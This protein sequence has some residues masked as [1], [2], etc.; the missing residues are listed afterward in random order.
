[1]FN[2]GNTLKHRPKLSQNLLALAFYV[3]LSIVV[4][5]PALVHLRDRVLG[6]YPGDNFQFLWAL[7][8]TAHA[9]ID[10][11][12]SPFFDPSIYFPFGFSLF[13]NLGEVSPA[14][15][16]VS[17]PLTRLLGEVATYNLLI[18]TSFALTGFATFL[19]AR[20]LRAGFPGAL[21]A[22][23]GVGFCSYHFAHAGGHLSLASTQWIPFFFLYL[24]RILQRPSIRKA[25]LLGLFYA[26]SALVSWY[27]ASLLPIAA[28]LYLSLR[29]NYFKHPKR[30]ARL[31]KPGLA[32]V[33]CSAVLVLP[34][35]VPYVLALKHG[36]MET[37]SLEES[38]AFSASVADFFIPSVRHPLF[39]R[40]IAQHWRSGAN[41]LWGEWEV[42]LGTLIV[43][44]ALLGIIRS[45]D[46]RITAGLIAMG[47]GAF[48][49]ALGPTL[50]FVHPPSLRGAANLAPLSHIP[51]PVLALKDIPPFSFLRC[52][53]RMGFFLELA[54]SLLAAKGLTY[55]LELVP[56]RAI[57]RHAVAIIVISLAT[58]DSMAV[59]FGMALVA[60][61]PV[62][63]WL[64]AQPGKFAVMEYPIPEHAYSGPA[65]YST[66]LS[67]K[68][69]IMG[70]GSNPPNLRYFET[71]STFPSPQALDLLQRWGTRFVLVDEKLY[72]RGSEFWQLW[73]T[74]ASLEPAIRDSSRLQEVTALEG[75]HVYKLKS[76]EI[77][78]LSEELVSN[79]G[80]ESES[81]GEIQGWTLVGHPR[82]GR[83]G[84]KAHNGSNSCCVTTS[85][86]LVS[87]PIPIE[88][89]RC[90]LLELF[91]RRARSKPAHVR[92]Q[93]IWLDAA[94]HPLEPS[95]AAIR[96][97][98]ATGQWQPARD[99]FLAPAGSRYAMI[100][101]V[102][103]SG[104]ACLDDY[105]LREISSD[106]E[107]NLSAIPNPAVRPPGAKQ[108]RSSISWNSHSGAGAHVGLSINGQPETRF[109]EGPA[110]MRIFDIET[111]SRWEF[112]LYDGM[113]SAPVR[114]TAVTSETIPL[115]SA[116]PVIFQSP[117]ALGKTTISW[118]MPN[119][120]EAEVW[121]SH[122]GNPE[123]LFVRGAS[124]SQDAPW[125]ARGSTY[126]FR[127]YAA[128]PKRR[129][130]GKLTVRATEP[131]P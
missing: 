25:L 120:S 71:L 31:I 119:H 99:E 60:P 62:D 97:V 36:T 6:A 44:L 78:P 40:W 75:I 34:F 118:N 19:L 94:E 20:A 68:Q 59:P 72:Q 7:W 69:I 92:L 30:L 80:F 28:V 23:I 113:S 131:S 2:I 63:R 17:V 88:S 22:G 21:V 5:W 14:T 130:I 82:I 91:N 1:M 122:D 45:K 103:H 35:A 105:S 102:T 109:A 39:G 15:I 58:L 10:L 42:Y 77:Q 53:A 49:L 8:Y 16:L 83:S 93:V 112:R 79:P 4:T 51:L 96:F 124:G 73:Q 104:T 32:A 126:E 66:R 101:A 70:Y 85:D 3:I 128:L 41:G 13:R 38:Q 26:L 61:R 29:L 115:L 64:A 65:M 89:G 43:P 67:G 114:T 54:V 123:Q 110:G 86:Y 50:Y 90:Y 100:Y 47:A 98:E 117:S 81:G 121:V 84:T 74:W 33:A 57:A 111:G 125:I 11:H 52:W 18:I 48:V 106:C 76:R 87:N 56:R 12:R 127:L 108:S 37:R 55:L 129:L 116:S 46:R 24:E 107:P 27:Y 9:I 95:T